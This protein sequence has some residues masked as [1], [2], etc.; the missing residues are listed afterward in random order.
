MNSSVDGRS[1]A[2]AISRLRM[3]RAAGR[4]SF[5]RSLCT[6]SRGR[7]PGP[8]IDET[9]TAAE[10]RRAPC[11]LRH[12]SRPRQPGRGR[13]FTEVTEC[14]P[15]E[16]GKCEHRRLPP[17]DIWSPDR[18][19]SHRL[20][21][22]VGARLVSVDL[23]ERLADAHSRTL[24]VGDDDF[25][26]LD[27]V[28]VA[29]GRRRPNRFGVSQTRP[30]RT[31]RPPHADVAPSGISPTDVMRQRPWPSR[32]RAA[33]TLRPLSFRGPP[34]PSAVPTSASCTAPGRGWGGARC[35]GDSF[36]H[37]QGW[38][39]TCRTRLC[40]SGHVSTGPVG[41]LT[42]FERLLLLP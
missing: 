39:G 9:A 42:P 20:D 8:R 5:A 29:G 26:R 4:T 32:R 24:L 21:L 16:R 11:A 18:C 34:S 22:D 12:L 13:R 30:G 23:Q 35:D 17:Q 37:G 14:G 15:R 31:R 41:A 28:I 40:R 33:G 2:S 10:V 6:R 3:T 27:L 25:D 1:A 7:G 19:R 36:G 38:H